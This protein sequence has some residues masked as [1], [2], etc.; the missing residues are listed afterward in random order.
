M[1]IEMS[2]KTAHLKDTTTAP[3]MHLFSRDLSWYN[4]YLTYKAAQICAILL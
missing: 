3:A 4:S 1:L 2:S